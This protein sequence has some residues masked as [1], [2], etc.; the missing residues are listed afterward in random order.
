MFVIYTT[1]FLVLL[2]FVRR[3]KNY[4]FCISFPKCIAKA[5]RKDFALLT[6]M[7]TGMTYRYFPSP[8]FSQHN[9]TLKKQRSCT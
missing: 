4:F 8:L 1:V 7:K 9:D 3:V 6:G 5:E 2:Q